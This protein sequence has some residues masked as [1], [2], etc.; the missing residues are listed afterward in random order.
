MKLFAVKGST[1]KFFKR[2]SCIIIDDTLLNKS[3]IIDCNGKFFKEFMFCLTTVYYPWLLIKHSTIECLPKMIYQALP[4]TYCIVI[5]HQ[6]TL[7]CI[8]RG[9][10]YNIYNKGVGH[11]ASIARQHRFS[12]RN[13]WKYSIMLYFKKVVRLPKIE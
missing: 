11:P 13:I 2:V 8:T 6:F 5:E 9:Y 10:I 4:I 1:I 7:Y 12:L 3:I